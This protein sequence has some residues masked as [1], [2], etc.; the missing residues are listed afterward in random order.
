MYPVLDDDC[1]INPDFCDAMKI[2]VPYCTGDVHLGTRS[3]AGPATWG[4]WFDGHLNFVA[5]VK[6]WNQMGLGKAKNV[7]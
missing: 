3:S 4:V 6:M 5:M 1:S 2:Y 7:L